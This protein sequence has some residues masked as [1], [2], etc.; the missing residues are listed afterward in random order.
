MDPLAAEF[1]PL[2]FRSAFIYTRE[3][4]PAEYLRHH[5]SFEQKLALARQF[6]DEQRVRRE[7][8]VD[9]LDGACHR[10][11]GA[12]PNMTW[13]ILRGGTIAYK[14][15]WTDAADVRDAMSGIARLSDLRRQGGRL[16]PF[17]T[18]RLGFRVV[19]QAAFNAGL[20]RNG[21]Q[22]VA[23]FAAFMRHTPLDRL[24]E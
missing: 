14:A 2:G 13:I 5:T 3:A 17:W 8:L 22:A 4:H 21:P 15:A 11:Y 23:D 24:G 18:E 10:D 16:A 7:I 19:D 1:A 9:A 6:R 12:L 20:E